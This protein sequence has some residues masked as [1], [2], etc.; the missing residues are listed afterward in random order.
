MDVA[1]HH[2][3]SNSVIDT[4][5]T[6]RHVIIAMAGATS[7]MNISS[8]GCQR[9]PQH[10]SAIFMTDETIAALVLIRQ[11]YQSHRFH[12]GISEENYPAQ[13]IDTPVRE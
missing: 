4:S 11:H 5:L 12:R 9:A 10:T 1:A 3:F 2:P 7:T 8:S 13:F 6:W